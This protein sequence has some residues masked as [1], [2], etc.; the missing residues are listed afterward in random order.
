LASRK[1]ITLFSDEVYRDL[2]YETSTKLPSAC[3][4]NPT[5]ISLGVM[6]KSYGL[7]GLRIGWIAS[8]NRGVMEQ[9]AELKD[10]TTI[11]SSAPS[12]FLAEI[13]VRHRQQVID[14]NRQIIK[15]NLILL[16]AFF[17]A[18]QDHFKWVRPAAGPIAFPI[19]FG[20]DIESFCHQLVT[21]AGVLL[22]PGTL[23]HHPGN[24]FRIGFGRRNMPESLERLERFLAGKFGE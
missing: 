2:E 6:S 16:D 21:E 11:C 10:Y 20:E 18:H 22:L 15:G 13:A 1:G 7:A 12:E 19:L 9:M 14:R 23:F 4:I 5:A 3:E 24:H 17:Q 8:H